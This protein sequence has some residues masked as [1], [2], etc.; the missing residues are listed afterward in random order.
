MQKKLVQM[1]MM[2]MSVCIITRSPNKVDWLSAIGVL[3]QVNNVTPVYILRL[4]L[5]YTSI[6]DHD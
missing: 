1:M 2:M 3:T 4:T 5:A 6:L